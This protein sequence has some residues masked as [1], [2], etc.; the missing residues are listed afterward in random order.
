MMAIKR[1]GARRSNFCGAGVGTTKLLGARCRVETV[2][3]QNS[4]RN[5]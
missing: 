1:G 4:W 5:G 2:K 3:Q